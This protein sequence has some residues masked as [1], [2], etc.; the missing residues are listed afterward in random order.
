MSEQQHRTA[1]TTSLRALHLDLL[2][3]TFQ[4]CDTNPFHNACSADNSNGIFL[5]AAN[6]LP[7]VRNFA[8]KTNIDPNAAQRAYAAIDD[9]GYTTTVQGQGS[10]VA[11]KKKGGDANVGDWPLLGCLAARN[12]PHARSITI[13]IV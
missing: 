10:T 13:H 6:I 9:G 2:N 4:S 3:P 7:S 1:R 5:I 11:F 12:N 8:A